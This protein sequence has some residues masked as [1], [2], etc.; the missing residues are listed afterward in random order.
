[1]LITVLMITAI[2]A[3]AAFVDLGVSFIGHK[4]L[5]E[6]RQTGEQNDAPFQ[7]TQ[8]ASWPGR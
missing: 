5:E 3:A 7:A 6:E 1:M 8:V 2:I 4:L